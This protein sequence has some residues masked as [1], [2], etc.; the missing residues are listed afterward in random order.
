M[1]QYNKLSTS[2]E[3]FYCTKCIDRLPCFTDSFFHNISIRSSDTE[4]SN[5]GSSECGTYHQNVNTVDEIESECNN[6]IFDEL[7]NLRR[8]NPNKFLIAYLNIN[9][10]RYKFCYISELLTAN[11]VDMLFL[12]ETKIDDSFTDTQFQVNNYHF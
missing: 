4:F 8:K 1:S 6:D 11:I 12:S 5:T 3:T 10:L 2:D 9:S 7:K